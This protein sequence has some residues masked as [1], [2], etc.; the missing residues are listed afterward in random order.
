MSQKYR[1][2]FDD[3]ETSQRTKSFSLL[4]TNDIMACC[5]FNNEKVVVDKVKNIKFWF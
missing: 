2:R 1:K 5:R 3:Y 4:F